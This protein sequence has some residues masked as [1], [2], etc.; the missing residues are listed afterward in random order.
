V[1]INMCLGA[2]NWT[3]KWYRSTGPRTPRELGEEIAGALLSVVAPVK[4]GASARS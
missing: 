4:D 1:F 3:Y 2:V